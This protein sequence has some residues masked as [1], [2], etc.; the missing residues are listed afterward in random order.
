MASERTKLQ[1]YQNWLK[2][3][4]ERYK[5]DE[6]YREECRRKSR[7][8]HRQ[9]SQSKEWRMAKAAYQRERYNIR[10]NII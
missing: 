9:H 1:S 8:Y 4:R 5:N 6:A 10:K 3:R 2:R 7:E